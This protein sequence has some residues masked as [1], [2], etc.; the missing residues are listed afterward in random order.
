MD[1]CIDSFPANHLVGMTGIEIDAETIRRAL[2]PQKGDKVVTRIGEG[3]VLIELK[4][5]HKRN[6][7]E[8]AKLFLTELLGGERFHFT[9]PKKGTYVATFTMTDYENED[10][11]KP[12][13]VTGSGTASVHPNDMAVFDPFVGKAIALLRAYRDV[14][15]TTGSYFPF[16]EELRELMA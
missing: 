9:S 4:K 5:S 10:I 13:D 6:R 2:Q 14:C 8:L 15:L 16:D 12:I 1:R 11:E 3:Y 7:R